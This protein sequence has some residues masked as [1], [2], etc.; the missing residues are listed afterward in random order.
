MRAPQTGGNV[1]RETLFPPVLNGTDDRGQRAIDNQ[2]AS[3][4]A[5][6]PGTTAS[7]RRAARVSSSIRGRSGSQVV[8][9]DDGQ[10]RCDRRL[11]AA[12]LDLGGEC[13]ER[14]DL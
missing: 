1:A 12:T 5:P 6:S 3:E 2:N 4:K 11:L 13:L 14:C 10:L 9:A 8:R 7:A